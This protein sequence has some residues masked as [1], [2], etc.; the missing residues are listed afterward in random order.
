MTDLI[1]ILTVTQ[2]NLDHHHLYLADIRDFFPADAIGGPSK[3]TP[4]FC[5][6][7][8]EWS[9]GETVETDIAGDKFIFRSRAWLAAFFKRYCIRAGDHLI[10]ERLDHHTYRL[11]P[12]TAL[13]P[14][15]LAADEDTTP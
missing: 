1:R 11:R 14:E 6:V 2:A 13:P 10:L 12:L 9:D 8:I 7:R 5:P 4:A 15:G 3:L